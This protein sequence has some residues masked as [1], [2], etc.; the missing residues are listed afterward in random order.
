M[1]TG[2]V[3]ALVD[4]ASLLWRMEVSASFSMGCL[5]EVSWLQE[6]VSVVSLSKTMSTL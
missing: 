4:A 6:V 1:K 3:Y 5:D 2:V